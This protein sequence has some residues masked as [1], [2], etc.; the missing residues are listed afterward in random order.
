L[1][2]KG[3][4]AAGQQARDRAMTY[5][6]YATG[7]RVSELVGLTLE[8]LD[9][10]QGYVRVN[11]KGDKERIVPFPP[12]VGK[13]LENYLIEHRADFSPKTQHLFL[14]LTGLALTRQ[15]YWKTLNRLA[16]ESGF[17]R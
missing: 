4:R 10:A 12:I 2:Y 7:L 13:L 9:L 6:L 17:T 16:L 14:N 15:A 11:G 8:Q 1:K 5:L 3:P